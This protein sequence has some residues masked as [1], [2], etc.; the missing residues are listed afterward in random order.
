MSIRRSCLTAR[1]PLYPL[2]GRRFLACP[3]NPTLLRPLSTMDIAPGSASAGPSATAATSDLEPTAASSIQVISHNQYHSPRILPSSLD[4]NPLAQFQTWFREALEPPAGIPQVAEPEAMCISTA[5]ARGVPSSR[6]VL[7][8]EADATGFVFYTN[9][10]SRKSRELL[11]NPYA[12]IALYWREVSRQVRAV[13]RV[14]QLT[15]AE[16]ERYFGSRPRGSR[17]GAWASEQSKVVGEDELQRR[18][19]EMQS[20]FEGQVPCPEHW[21]GWRIVPL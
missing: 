3:P 8:K 11:E 4:P 6:F 15:R 2:I 7:L 19:D 20:K 1:S 21:G 12:S 18:V 5:T 16:S 13:G 17:I 9:Y 10:T 14:E